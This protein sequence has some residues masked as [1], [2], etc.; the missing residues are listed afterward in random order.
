M[1]QLQM[2]ISADMK[3][4]TAAWRVSAHQCTSCSNNLDDVKPQAASRTASGRMH[5]MNTP[6]ADS[7]VANV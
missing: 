3:A 6:H 1:E 7:K 2:E 5:H 4:Q